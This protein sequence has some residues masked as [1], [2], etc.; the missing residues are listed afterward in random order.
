MDE[1]FYCV[2]YRIESLPSF[3]SFAIFHAPH[4]CMYK[5]GVNGAIYPLGDGI[6][7]S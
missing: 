3:M 1:R 4:L 6:L 2:N 5:Q 7:R